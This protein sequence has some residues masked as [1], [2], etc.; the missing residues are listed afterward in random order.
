MVNYKVETIE[1]QV[2]SGINFLLDYTGDDGFTKISA[3]V[4]VDLNL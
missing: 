4:N 3:M 1:Y 2:V